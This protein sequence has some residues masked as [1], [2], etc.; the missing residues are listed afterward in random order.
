MD[1]KDKTSLD[2]KLR[3]PKLGLMVYFLASLMTSIHFLLLRDQQE[4]AYQL[5]LLWDEDLILSIDGKDDEGNS[6]DWIDEI[7]STSQNS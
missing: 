6:Y 1:I 7:P 2:V 3:L 4:R 5:E